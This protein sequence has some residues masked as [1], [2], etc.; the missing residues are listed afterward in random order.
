M[1]RFIEAWLSH[2]VKAYHQSFALSTRQ[3]ANR[4]ALPIIIGFK[5]RQHHATGVVN[6]HAAVFAYLGAALVD[7]FGMFREEVQARLKHGIGSALERQ[8]PLFDLCHIFPKK[9][10]RTACLL[11]FSSPMSR[12]LKLGLEGSSFSFIFSNNLASSAWVPGY[13]KHLEKRNPCLFTLT[14]VIFGK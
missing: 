1:Q 5:I 8:S 4:H 13:C 10:G 9:A 14:V 12:V 2:A 11:I 3:Q 7:E 6:R